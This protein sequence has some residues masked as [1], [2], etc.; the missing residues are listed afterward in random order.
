MLPHR[1]ED[2]L[3]V[4]G[5]GEHGDHGVVFRQHDHVLAVGTI[6]AVAVARHPELE[7][8]SL[9]PV[10]LLTLGVRRL[11]RGGSSDPTLRKQAAPVPHPVVEVELAESGD[12]VEVGEH[13]RV[14]EVAPSL[15]APAQ[16]THADRIE[17]P[18][19]QRVE[20]A[21]AVD[22]L[23]DARQR[24]HRRLV[25]HEQRPRRDVGRDREEASHW[26]VRVG[27][28]R[29]QQHLPVVAGGHRRDVPDAHAPRAFVSVAEQLRQMVGNEVV[30]PDEAVADREAER[31][32]GERLAQRVDEPDA[33]SCVRRPVPLDDPLAMSLDDQPVRL[34]A[35]VSLD[36]IEERG[37]ARRSD[38]LGRWGAAHHRRLLA[39]PACPAR[40]RRDVCGFTSVRSGCRRRGG[41]CR[42]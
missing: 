3:H 13:P 40:A 22:P 35:G 32:T 24:Q 31:G 2:T 4:F 29:L 39:H 6:T 23:H 26:I 10:L 7:P 19:A 8:I 16:V 20:Q 9:P 17:H 25:V 42:R 15:L 33:L 36:R 1:V 30:E 14:A 21:L 34:D 12:R 5:A 28:G 18:L 38:A 11:D 41:S 27:G 37:D